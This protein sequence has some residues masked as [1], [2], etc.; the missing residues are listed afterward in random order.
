MLTFPSDSF[1][2]H[3]LPL[4]T[5]SIKYRVGDIP[6]DA[7]YDIRYTFWPIVV[8]CDAAVL[9][10]HKNFK[11]AFFKHC[12]FKTSDFKLLKFNQ[13]YNFLLQIYN[14]FIFD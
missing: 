13:L 11:F 12:G 10:G 3:Y 2:N 9:R 8:T 4:N 6:V 1:F 14:N 5:D 7:I